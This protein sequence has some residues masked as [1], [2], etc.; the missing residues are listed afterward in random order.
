MQRFIDIDKLT[1]VCITLVVFGHLLLPQ[2]EHLSHY[3]VIREFIY[4]FHMPLFMFLSGFL[5]ALS[6]KSKGEKFDYLNYIKGKITKFLPPYVLFS[7]IFTLVEFLVKKK[8]F[9]DLS[10]DLLYT[11]ILPAK[12]PAGFL[13]YIYVLFLF[14]ISI[15]F[16]LKLLKGQVIFLVIFGILFQFVNH[17]ITDVLCLKLYSY[18]FFFVSIGVLVY[19]NIDK[20][21][22]LLDKLGWF[23]IFLF[24]V[25]V[26]FDLNYDLITKFQLGLVSIPSFHFLA[27]RFDNFLPNFIVT[28]GKSSF[29]IYLM[30]TLFIGGV[31]LVMIKFNIPFNYVT[32]FFLFLIGLYL[33]IVI[34]KYVIDKFKIIKILIP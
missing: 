19:Q 25:L 23:F 34:K 32:L 16:L 13:W 8:S 31:S 12:S 29:Y 18:Y 30:N 2:F 33:P 17:H 9:N 22:F 11:Y 21:Y 5:I 7:T 14:Y 27:R 26:A 4:K 1:G 20:Y 28:L 15:P 24:I 10:L 6:L 3:V